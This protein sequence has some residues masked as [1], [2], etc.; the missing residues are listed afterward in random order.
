MT[1]ASPRIRT[2][3]LTPVLHYQV[4]LRSMSFTAH[5]ILNLSLRAGDANVDSAGALP[6]LPNAPKYPCPHLS[7][8]EVAQYLE[9]LYQKSWYIG[10][11]VSKWNRQ[12]RTPL[13]LAKKMDF[14]TF[15]D[16]LKYADQLSQVVR[17]EN[18]RHLVIDNGLL[19]Y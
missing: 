11:R 5:N 9:P 3:A 10:L 16:A 2:K 7:D 15:D 4:R 12:L 17:A 18:V 14:L 6:E 8:E 13:V 19:T 1:R